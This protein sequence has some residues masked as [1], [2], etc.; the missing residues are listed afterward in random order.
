MKAQARTTTRSRRWI[1][2]LAATGIAVSAA[3][4]WGGTSDVE[5]SKPGLGNS[6]EVSLTEAGK[7]EV[8]QAADAK[9]GRRDNSAGL[10]ERRAINPAD[11]LATENLS[12]GGCLPQYGEAGQCLPAVPPSLSRHLQEMKKA[13]VDPASMPHP[14]ACSEVRDY[15]MDGLIVRKKNVDPQ[16]LDVN[17][18]GIA[19]GP[20][21]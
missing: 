7:A 8:G 19:C 2:L 12:L 14:W 3:L 16:K 18:D 9:P 1:P 5:G 10:K 20:G 6:P 11:V 4:V 21:D 13:G 15:F 17:D